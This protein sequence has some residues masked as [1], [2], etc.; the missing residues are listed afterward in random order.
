VH[1]QAVTYIVQRFAS[2]ATLFYLL[3]LVLYIKARLSLVAAG[4]GRSPAKGQGLR[5]KT[6][7][8]GLGSLVSAVLAM[9]TKEISFT[10]PF[11]ILL[12]EFMFFG[13]KGLNLKRF[14]YLAPVLLTVLVLPL[15]LVSIDK[16][17]GDIIGELREATQET[18]RIPRE[19]YLLTQFRVIVTYIRLLF[20]PV[21][22]NLDYHY[23]RY[24]SL[25]EPEVFLSFF[26][27]LS[28]LGL[29]VY[30][31]T[32]SRKTNN[33]YTLLA[34]FG[35][36]WFFITLSVESSVIPIR[37]V[38][39][40]HRLYLPSVGAVVAFCTIAFYLLVH[41][42]PKISLLVATSL[43]L[44][45]TASPLGVAT[46]VRNSVWKDKVTLWEDVVRKSPGK[47]RGQYNLG[48]AYDDLG[49]TDEAIEKF[50]NAISINPNYA[51]AYNNLGVAY[52]KKGQNDKKIQALN[53]ALKL[54]PD[55]A[56]A[57]NNLGN[58]YAREGRIDEAIEEY[59][60]ALRLKPDYANAYSNLG[61]VYA[62]QGR[63]DEA[64]E[65]FLKA[66]RLEPDFAEAH[67]NLGLAYQIKGLKNEAIMEF[68]EVLKLKPQTEQAR[69][70]L[71]SLSSN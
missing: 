34:S 53:I 50:R 7:L 46:Y 29:A 47:P 68:K 8:L 58:A 2:L 66:L 21:N 38:I 10:L 70:I 52:G 43:F 45:V 39:F 31:F 57:H 27:L 15:S 54:E 35:I 14:L 55:F 48:L 64:I 69:K 56:K 32:R 11:V 41:R 65:E 16:P 44:L 24:S 60:V 49:R 62:S 33:I 19:V 20:L 23:P 67:F 26:F 59:R 6:I 51:K 22:Q 17:L 25:F 42:K 9:K 3:S 30:L 13:Y 4:Q 63:I 71:Q 36:F 5:V 18:E 40:E 61:A 1:T 12:Y 37:D 28:F